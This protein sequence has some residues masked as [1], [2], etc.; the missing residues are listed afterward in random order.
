MTKRPTSSVQV[1]CSDKETITRDH[2]GQGRSENR[3]RWDESVMLS[4]YRP[5][6][7]LPWHYA[8][9]KYRPPQGAVQSAKSLLL[10]SAVAIQGLQVDIPAGAHADVSEAFF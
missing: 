6:A 10:I 1:A 7:W 4:A 3:L 8:C 5:V 2:V 9:C